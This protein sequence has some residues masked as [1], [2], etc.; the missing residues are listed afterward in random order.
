MSLTRLQFLCRQLVHRHNNGEPQT[1]L[2]EV[3]T[4][5]PVAVQECFGPPISQAGL[6]RF[7]FAR[8]A[9]NPNPSTQLALA[10][11][12]AQL[13]LPDLRAQQ[14]KLVLGLVYLIILWIVAA[15]MNGIFA[16][17]VIPAMDQFHAQIASMRMMGPVLVLKLSPLLFT[18]GFIVIG[19]LCLRVNQYCSFAA[20]L[21]RSWL[22]Y[23]LPKKI[24]QLHQFICQLLLSPLLPPSER[25][26]LCN[27]LWQHT[28]DPIYEHQELIALNS[29]R[30]V[31]QITKWQKLLHIVTGVVVIASIV[32][33][34][35]NCYLPLFHTAGL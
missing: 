14:R 21:S 25:P 12:Y 16:A 17:K 23:L 34:Y 7:I 4:Q 18:V 30:L 20:Q 15:L 35:V 27:W 28:A 19:I 9:A 1:N 5:I 33:I 24:T 22:D 26:E 29:H 3:T 13:R 8:I 32:S 6:D 31:E 2:D 10:N 11:F